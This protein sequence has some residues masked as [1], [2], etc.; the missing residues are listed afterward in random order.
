MHH[1]AF[2]LS[3]FQRIVEDAGD[4]HVGVAFYHVKLQRLQEV[5]ALH[6]V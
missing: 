4:A 6:A 2:I 5:H 1:H 3:Y